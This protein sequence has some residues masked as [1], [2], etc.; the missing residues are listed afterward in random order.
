MKARYRGRG[1]KAGVCTALL[2][3]TLPLS[4]G[5]AAVATPAAPQLPLPADFTG[6][7]MLTDS[8]PAG[9]DVKRPAPFTAARDRIAD[10]RG[11]KLMVGAS[12]NLFP[13]VNLTGNVT[14]SS[15]VMSMRTW[16][17]TLT[18]TT[19]YFYAAQAGDAYVAHAATPKGV[20]EIS[21]VGDGAYR[22]IELD[23]SKNREDAPGTLKVGDRAYFPAHVDDATT[24]SSSGHDDTR[25]PELQVLEA[26]IALMKADTQK[27]AEI[28][29]TAN[30][31]LD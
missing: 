28:I 8:A 29:R 20:Y 6:T 3:L 24:W 1:F 16:R 7:N 26:F 25:S 23:Q 15:K 14:S 2:A 10:F 22:V 21:K 30:I 13:G 18:N 27:F 12:F 19:G 31:R 17:G 5:Q 11:S 4:L 9:A